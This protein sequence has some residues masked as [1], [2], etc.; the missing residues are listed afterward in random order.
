MLLNN[1]TKEANLIEHAFWFSFI[2]FPQQD[3]ISLDP[4]LTQVTNN[5]LHQT[6]HYQAYRTKNDRQ[7]QY[8]IK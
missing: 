5:S 1:N 4:K 8:A 3:L 6:P 2:S 7:K